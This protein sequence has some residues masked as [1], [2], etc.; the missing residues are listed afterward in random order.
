MGMIGNLS[1][2]LEDLKKSGR[3][4]RCPEAAPVRPGRLREE[5][6][7]TPSGRFEFASQLI[8][9][10]GMEPLPV[11]RDSVDD[12][13]PEQFPMV[14]VTGAR[15]PNALHSRLHDV[16]WLRSMCPQPQVQM[17]P[18]DAQPLGIGQGDWVELYNATGV[19]RVKADLT[20]KVRPGNLY[21]FHGYRE[22]NA[23]QLVAGGHLDPYTGF[24]GFKSVRCALRKWEGGQRE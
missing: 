10:V 13:D 24:P 21:L 19:I 8:A 2:T 6:F 18:R 4:I 5:G 17:N 12:A 22:A 16:P 20:E 7:P 3:P 9:Q 15:I 14:L 1:V 11:Y 23:N